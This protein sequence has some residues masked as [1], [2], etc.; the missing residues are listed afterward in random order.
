MNEAKTT[1]RLV[2]T[3]TAGARTI[4][5][6]ESK[7]VLKLRST[8]QGKAKEKNLSRFRGSS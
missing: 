1:G 7:S 8:V 3:A 6:K 2:G 5:F 4:R